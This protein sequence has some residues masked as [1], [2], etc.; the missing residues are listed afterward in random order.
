MASSPPGPLG[1]FRSFGGK[2]LILLLIFLIFP[3]LV[4]VQLA[5]ADRARNQLLIESI[6]REGELVVRAL[7][8]VLLT[9][10]TSPPEA[11]QDA[12]DRLRIPNRTIKV[13]ARPEVLGVPP[14]FYY[15]AAS[16]TVSRE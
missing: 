6:Q 1:L 11:L 12:L 14:R 4:Y 8:P 7:K 10:E 16:P 15:L 5:S 3:I 13:L 2:L 9:F